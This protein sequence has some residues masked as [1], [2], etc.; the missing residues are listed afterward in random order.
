MHSLLQCAFKQPA[1]VARGGVTVFGYLYVQCCRFVARFCLYTSELVFVCYGFLD[2]HQLL[3]CI[4]S[5]ILFQFVS[6]NMGFSSLFKG[7]ISWNNYLSAKSTLLSTNNHIY[8]C[9]LTFAEKRFTFQ[10]IVKIIALP[11]C[12][13]II[14]IKPIIVWKK[15]SDNHFWSLKTDP[16]TAPKKPTYKDLATGLKPC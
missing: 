5:I 7:K 6:E 2:Q 1:S 13:L 3:V 10:F 4:N 12:W 15:S 11:S 8:P 14:E 16:I 9:H